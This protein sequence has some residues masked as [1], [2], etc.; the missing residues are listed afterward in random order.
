MNHISYQQQE[1]HQKIES[2]LI[3]LA[4]FLSMFFIFSIPWCN[5]VWFALTMFAIHTYLE[6]KRAR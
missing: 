3:K 4:L 6:S 1:N 5:V 2:S